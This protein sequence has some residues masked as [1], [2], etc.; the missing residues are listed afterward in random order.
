MKRA[1]LGGWDEGLQDQCHIHGD[2]LLG[3]SEWL[4]PVH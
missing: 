4:Q 1:Q 3:A 2:S